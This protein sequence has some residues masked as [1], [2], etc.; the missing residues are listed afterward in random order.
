MKDP[1]TDFQF[2][3]APRGIALEAKI[4]VAEVHFGFNIVNLL[5]FFNLLSRVVKLF[6]LSYFVIPFEM[7]L[8]QC[9]A[10]GV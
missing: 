3:L 7:C 5:I 10:G 6:H 2:I 1:D 4:N 9:W 8:D